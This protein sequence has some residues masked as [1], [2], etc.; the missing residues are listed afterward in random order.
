MKDV[1]CA[2]TAF[3]VVLLLALFIGLVGCDS[4]Q[5][6]ETRDEVRRRH[7]RNT[8]LNEQQL[9]EDW[10]MVMLQDQPSKLTDKKVP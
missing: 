7:E 6:G 3:V 1:I 5:Q 8:R 4:P 9:S 2:K 10:D